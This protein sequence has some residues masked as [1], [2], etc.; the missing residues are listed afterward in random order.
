MRTIGVVVALGLGTCVAS[1]GDMTVGDLTVQGKLEVKKVSGL[2]SMPTNGMVLYYDFRTNEETVVTDRSCSGNDGNVCNAT[3]V[4]NGVL[5]GCYSF[6]SGAQTNITVNNGF[7]YS[8]GS[9]STWVCP[10]INTNNEWLNTIMAQSYNWETQGGRELRMRTNS[11]EFYMDPPASGPVYS[12]FS[13]SSIVTGVWYH[14]TV[15]WKNSS[16]TMRLYVN[17]A[18]EDQETFVPF[19]SGCGSFVIGDGVNGLMDEVRI[20]N[21]ELSAEEAACLYSLSVNPNAGMVLFHEGIQLLKPLGD[22]PMGTFTNH[23]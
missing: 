11:F 7:D 15:T 19:S 20:Y 4:S 14:V 1:A 9:Y 23:P 12:C 17:G 18:L 6:P 21:R 22:I 3:W 13:T 2:S 5:D 10:N 8:E 16:N